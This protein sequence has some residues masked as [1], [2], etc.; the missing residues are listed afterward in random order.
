M[1]HTNSNLVT[2]VFS[3]CLGSSQLFLCYL[4]KLTYTI[5]FVD[6]RINLMNLNW[7][8]GFL[9]LHRNYYAGYHPLIIC[10]V[11]ATSLIF[12]DLNNSAMGV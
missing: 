6:Q 2:V 5:A 7:S 3:Y 10:F 12:V 9:F 8:C 1:K 4:N 11:G